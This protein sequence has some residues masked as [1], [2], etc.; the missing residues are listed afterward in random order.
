ME[1]P[2]IPYKNIIEL[3]FTKMLSPIT[4]FQLICCYIYKEK[5]IPAGN[6]MLPYVD[7][8][9]AYYF[10]YIVFWSG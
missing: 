2:I 5:R 1:F 10:F 6:S 9:F 3:T 7:F 4:I 8:M